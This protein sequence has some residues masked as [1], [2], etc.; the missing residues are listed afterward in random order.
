MTTTPPPLQRY[1]VPADYEELVI[2]GDRQY[3]I[4]GVETVDNAD[5]MR[6]FLDTVVIPPDM[7]E[8]D[9]GTQVTLKH[10]DPAK[11]ITIDARGMGDFFDSAFDVAITDRGAVPS[12]VQLVP[13]PDNAAGVEPTPPSRCHWCNAE[14]F[15]HVASRSHVRCLN[16]KCLAH[17]PEAATP[18]LA[19]A[20][21]NTI[22]R[23]PNYQARAARWITAC[24]G[25]TVAQNMPE[26]AHRFL[27]EALE[28]AQATGMSR[29][30]A[31]TLTNYVFSR[32]K[33]DI[34]QEIG[35]TMVCLAGLAHAAG[36]DMERSAIEQLHRCWVNIDKIH[37]K[38]LDK[39][40]S[41]PLPGPVS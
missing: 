28:L 29:E 10:P 8:T 40:R 36:E 35:D 21:W 2:N 14:P 5:S 16:P 25:Q 17:G 27:E 26:R 39:P 12:H 24:F 11:V 20:K 38:W 15:L 9:D 13:S 32:T 37:K 6:R 3:A 1:D 41:G 33:G 22:A 31:T 30:D 4:L 34:G 18:T 7:I 19:I 23:R